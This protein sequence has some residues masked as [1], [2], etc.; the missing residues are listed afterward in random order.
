MAGLVGGEFSKICKKIP[1]ENGKM[2]YFGL[3]CKKISKPRVKFSR[4]WMKNTIGRENFE[5]ISRK[6]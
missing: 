3:F 2:H 1:K 6:I 4:V 5:K